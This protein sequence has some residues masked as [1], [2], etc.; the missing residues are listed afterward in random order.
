MPSTRVNA[1]VF[2]KTGTLTTGSFRVTSM[3]AAGLPED[4]LL[5]LV[6]SVEK[7]ST[8]PVGTKP[9]PASQPNGVWNLWK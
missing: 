2:D 9:L 1:I 7:K 3:Q 6:L 8:H 4:E 5:R